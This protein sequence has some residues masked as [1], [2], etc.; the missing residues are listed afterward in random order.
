[1]GRNGRFGCDLGKKEPGDE[2]ANG[3]K[4]WTSIPTK[5]GTAEN[6]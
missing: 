1:M 3:R 4:K 6:K 5:K 2:N